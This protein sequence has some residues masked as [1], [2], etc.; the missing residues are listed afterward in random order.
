VDSRLKSWVDDDGQLW[1]I[2]EH[3]TKPTR[4]EDLAVDP[5]DGLRWNVCSP[6]HETEFNRT[7]DYLI[8]RL[9]PKIP[10]EYQ[11]GFEY[12]MTGGEYAMAIDDLLTVI[13]DQHIELSPVESRTIH[14]LTKGNP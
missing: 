11:A 6:C 1:V 10:V 9:M 5:T 12:M 14:V 3:C 7:A 13:A 8:R 2:C 4:S